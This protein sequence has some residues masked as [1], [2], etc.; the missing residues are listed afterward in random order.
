MV[1]RRI[2]VFISFQVVVG[3]TLCRIVIVGRQENA[4][5]IGTSDTE[6]RNMGYG[7]RRPRTLR[8]QLVPFLITSHTPAATQHLVGHVSGVVTADVI[9]QVTEVSCL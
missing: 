9:T 8:N 1:V 2:S 3:I 4:I 7:I 6:A 5:A